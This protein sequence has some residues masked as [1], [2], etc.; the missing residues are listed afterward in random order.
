MGREV[1]SVSARSE[2]RQSRA[3]QSLLASHDDGLLWH[4]FQPEA[5]SWMRCFDMIDGAHDEAVQHSVH[6]ER[7]A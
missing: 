6:V 7:V 2:A 4:V 1:A 3:M 5:A